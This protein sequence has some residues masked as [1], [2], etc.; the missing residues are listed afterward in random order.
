MS[1]GNFSDDVPETKWMTEQGTPD[2]RMTLMKEFWFDDPQGRRWSAPQGYETDGTTIPRALWTLI[3]SPFTGD[4][5]RAA[6]VHDKACVEAAGD[7][8]ARRVADKMF[9]HACREG[10]CSIRQAT[11]MYIGVRVGAAWPLQLA[12][13]RGQ[14]SDEPRIYRTTEEKRLEADFQLVAEDVISLQES[15]DPDELE[16]RVD[17]SIAKFLFLDAVHQ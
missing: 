14:A 12:R 3:G 11:V 2:R 9:Y 13:F 6:I 1:H 4:Y 16:R 15:D 17:A 8:T 7:K 5:R 10:G